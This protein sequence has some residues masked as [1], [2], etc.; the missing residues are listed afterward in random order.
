MPASKGAAESGLDRALDWAQRHGFDRSLMTGSQFPED[1]RPM[2]V[3]RLQPW[4]RRIG[5]EVRRPGDTPRRTVGL[6]QTSTDSP[7][8]K[9]PAVIESKLREAAAKDDVSDKEFERWRFKPNLTGIVVIHGIG[10]Q[11]AGQTLLDWTRP[12]ITV[13][14]DAVAADAER[15]AGNDGLLAPPDPDRGGI[16]DPVYKSNID[17]SG[18]TF[19]VLQVRVPRRAVETPEDAAADD[20]LWVFTETWWASEVRPPTLR[21][22]VG[23]L[24]EQGGVGRI[25]EGIQRNMFGSGRMSWLATASVQPFVSVIVSFALLLLIAGLAITRLIPIESIRSAAAL[26]LASTFLTDWFGGARTLLRDQAQSA[27]VRHRLVQS[28]KALRAYGCQRV[29]IVAHSGG[30]IVSL[31][32]L[33]D[34]AYPD[35]HVDKLI[36]IGEALN[37]GWRLEAT[38]PDDPD[39]ILP[40]GHRM[41]GNL[42]AKKRLIWRDFHGTHDPASSGPPDPP[43]PMR[44]DVTGL[45]RFTTERTYNL[46]SVVGDHGGYWDN[47]EHFVVPLIREID[48]PNG[49]RSGSRFYSDAAESALRA[50]RKERISFLRLWRRGTNT[51]P[52]LAILAAAILTSSGYLPTLGRAAIGLLG[53]IPLINGLDGLGND[54]AGLGASVALLGHRPFDAMYAL[55]LVV[56]HGAFAFAVFQAIV[57]SGADGLWFDRPRASAAIKLLDY[58]L[59]PVA[60]AVVMGVWFVRVGLPSGPGGLVQF[61]LDSTILSLAGALLGLYVF[62]RF[63]KWLRR[64]LRMPKKRMR[65]APEV[66]RGLAILLSA[67]FLGG[68]LV[69]MTAATIGVVLLFTGSD[70]RPAAEVESIREF[71]V[72]AAVALGLFSLLQKIGTWRWN[73]WDVRERFALRKAPLR[74]PSRYWAS[75]VGVALTVITVLGA[76]LVAVGTEDAALPLWNRD[77]WTM[78]VIGLAVGLIVL[79]IGKDVVDNDV[80]VDGRLT[81]ARSGGPS[82]SQV[83]PMP[84]GSAAGS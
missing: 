30:T 7:R 50:R 32:T 69:L 75:I 70:A 55:G 72:G 10:P 57:P 11:L 66:V 71:V 16:T 20:P 63:G 3:G 24:G 31:T 43:E 61:V 22:M 18:E 59:G 29:V 21:T 41:L 4:Q 26:K 42:A 12:I 68:L 38:N 19:P 56:L 15:T 45:D 73:S 46:M 77:G 17:F 14:G 67:A 36:T 44:S 39:P 84:T 13:L 54:L 33:T 49:D 23:W 52:I 47:D 28:I 74:R 25:V 64:E 34:P 58:L 78:L 60:L 76:I 82:P 65:L 35:L 81:G 80:E 62:A 83:E 8:P 37:L 48:V 40:P 6:V 9:D 79:S 51:L 2:V 1:V 53:Q 5:D 27:N